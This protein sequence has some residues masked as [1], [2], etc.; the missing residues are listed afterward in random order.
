VAACSKN[1]KRYSELKRPLRELGN[2]NN[3]GRVDS[4][5]GVKTIRA[6]RVCRPLIAEEIKFLLF[7]IYFGNK[8]ELVKTFSFFFRY[9]LRCLS[10]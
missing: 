8:I 2:N 7:R 10:L 1:D 3:N 6:V 5:R 4:A 9:L